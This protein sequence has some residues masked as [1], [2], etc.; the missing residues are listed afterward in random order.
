MLVR[1][2]AIRAHAGVSTC[3]VVRSVGAQALANLLQ[4]KLVVTKPFSVVTAIVTAMGVQQGAVAIARL[5]GLSGASTVEIVGRMFQR[6]R[7]LR[8]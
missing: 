7:R 1:H 5:S 4:I 6:G 2:D 8:G 3:C